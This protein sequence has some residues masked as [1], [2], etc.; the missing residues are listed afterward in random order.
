[1]RDSNVEAFMHLKHLALA[2]PDMRASSRFYTTYFGFREGPGLGL[3][4]N[5][6]GFRLALH[7]AAEPVHPPDLLHFGFDVMTSDDVWSLWKL[8]QLAQNKTD[9]RRNPSAPT[10]TQVR[11][12]RRRS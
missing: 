4:A 5:A 6:D 3:M 1:M 10:A 9:S 12:S 2:T 11:T 8:V 7:E